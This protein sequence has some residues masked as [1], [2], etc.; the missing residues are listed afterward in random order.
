ML[1]TYHLEKR[2]R[3]DIKHIFFDLDRTLWDFEKN[4][5]ETL[6]EIYNY[7]KLRERG[8]LSLNNFIKVYIKQN[9]I[10]WDK[11]RKGLVE[12]KTLRSS[13]FSN[14]LMEF[15]YSNKKLSKKIGDYYVN[16]SPVKKELL[17]NTFK[18]LDYLHE[19]YP[20][21]IITNGF[22]EV[23]YLKLKN[24]NLDKYFKHVITSEKSGVKKP[25]PRIF[26]Y[27]LKKA[28]ASP[29]NSIYIGD[30]LFVDMIGA[31]NVNMKQCYFNPYLEKHNE[32]LTFEIQN[33]IELTEIF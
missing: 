25:N 29:E 2:F 24:C 27:A 33:L 13:R 19:R 26:T 5:K 18:T 20:M 8:I 6:T 23:Q 1:E 28:N 16:E 21:Y 9:D 30:D 32:V 4:S 14:T 10:L 7:F 11:Y 15:G 22:E 31:K 17:P 3:M 12:K